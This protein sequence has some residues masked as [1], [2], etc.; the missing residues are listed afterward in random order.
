MM[1]AGI[2]FDQHTAEKVRLVY[3]YCHEKLEEILRLALRKDAET[4]LRDK[5]ESV[6]NGVPNAEEKINKL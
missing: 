1:E 3:L 4:M 2:P 5:I 6:L